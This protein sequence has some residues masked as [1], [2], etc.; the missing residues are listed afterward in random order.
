MDTDFSS[1][2]KEIIQRRPSQNVQYLIGLEN[3][4]TELKMI[5]SPEEYGRLTKMIEVAPT[6]EQLYYVNKIERYALA[7][8]NTELIDSLDFYPVNL[9]PTREQAKEDVAKLIKQLRQVQKFAQVRKHKKKRINKKWAKKYGY[10]EIN[11]G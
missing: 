7:G 11:N 8:Q 6:S 9:L 3:A 2:L 10:K 4:K 1:V 5:L